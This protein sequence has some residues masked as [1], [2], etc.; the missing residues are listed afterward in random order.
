ML[1]SAGQ[2]LAE[3]EDVVAVTVVLSPRRRRAAPRYLRPQR[4]QIR[5]STPPNPVSTHEQSGPY[6]LPLRQRRVGVVIRLARSLPR[7]R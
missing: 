4:G 1:T 6:H 7:P 5:I 2:V 3:I